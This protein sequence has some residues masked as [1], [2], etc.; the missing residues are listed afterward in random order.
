M[1]S[2]AHK[3]DPGDLGK[4]AKQLGTRLRPAVQ[5]GL[6]AGGRRALVVLRDATRRY[7]IR[8][9]G[10]FQRGWRA[11][12]S[13][14]DQL[15]LRNDAPYSLFVESGRRAGARQPPVMALVPWVQ[16]VLGVPERRARSVAFMVAR[17]ISRR[18]IPARPVLKSPMT[19]QHVAAVMRDEL[20]RALNEAASASMRGR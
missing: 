19:L 13:S 11:E 17:A 2:V 8:D 20:L 4:W 12:M 6:K 15:L 5:R 16:R 7:P 9:T 3:I 1:S 14:W 10:R 18:G